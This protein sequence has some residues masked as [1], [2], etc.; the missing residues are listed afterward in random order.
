MTNTKS[1]QKEE[2]A[3]IGK[4]KGKNLEYPLKNLKKHFI[5]LG[6]SG[7]GKTVLTKILIEECAMNKIPSIVVDVQGDLASLAIMGDQK[8]IE[9]HDLSLESYNWFKENVN[10]TIYTPISTKGI[11]LCINPLKLTQTKLPEEEIIPIMHA[12][13][14]SI[15]KLLG[16]N[17]S[18]DKGKS[19]EA[20]LYTLLKNS[21]D[22]KSSIDS[23][24]NL[25]NLIQ[26]LDSNLMG[27]VTQYMN[28]T[29]I[30]NLVKKVKFMTVGEKKL[31][32]QLGVPLD[33]E[34]LLKD[35]DINVIYLNTLPNQEEKEFFIT[36]LTTELYQ[37]ML[38]NPSDKI[39]CAYVIDEIAPYLPA[40]SEKPMTKT[41]LKLLF[42]QAR[43]YGVA[44]MI[45]TQN[46]GDI[47]YKAFAQFGSWA[48]GR[49]SV[50]QDIKKI[51]NTLK[52]LAD[53][54]DL[55]S[56]LPKLQ[57]GEFLLFAPD[58]SEKLI[59]LNARWLYTKHQTL[60]EQTIKE[61]MKDKQQKYKKYFVKETEVNQTKT[62]TEKNQIF[63]VEKE[64]TK[65]EKLNTCFISLNSE[66]A[67]KVAKKNRKKMFWLF[68]S[69]IESVAEIKQ[70]WHPYI[71]T[72]IRSRDKYLWGM[73]KTK[74]KN[75]I[76]FFDG[77]TGA[78]IKAKKRKHIE[79]PN[80][81]KLVSLTENQISVAKAIMLNRK[82]LS[83][84]EISDIT[85][86]SSNIVSNALEVLLKQAL[87]TFK[88]VANYK[89]WFSLN[90]FKAKSVRKIC[91]K[92]ILTTHC[93]ENFQ[94]PSLKI[95]EKSIIHF[96][97]MWFNEAQVEKTKI[98]YYPT[99][100]IT[101]LRKGHTRTILLN[102]A[103]KRI[104]KLH[105]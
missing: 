11:P 81:G 34:F 47:D 86:L 10:V 41:I 22:T 52:T 32:F 20:V 58:M 26:N 60:N 23:F 84:A 79:F 24:D 31:I 53:A 89:Q 51:E 28:E 25:A 55:V 43:K 76:V 21:Y 93:T 1:P 74:F 30:I 92:A 71:M 72:Q 17:T 91:T 75:H 102:G 45:A 105:F 56:T 94:L 78:I 50:K 6:S 48:I 67:M 77:K 87:I 35:S 63:K 90:P 57:P 19:A 69:P 16:Y 66:D 2:F 97:T 98:V 100:K 33:V 62:I 39:Q 73:I 44:C 65:K 18:N 15:S 5:A 29:E 38:S 3:L 12:I 83:N 99:Y 70:T 7:S 85:K 4:T 46:P 36:N 80:T 42:K 95:D 37:W 49:L 104:E 59:H 8:E 88:K 68:G 101:Y 40:T 82:P 61:L 64:I 96:V 9:K 14:T 103:T 13:A 27:E 54:G